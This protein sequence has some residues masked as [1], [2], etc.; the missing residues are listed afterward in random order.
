MSD[1]QYYTQNGQK[2]VYKDNALF[3]ATAWSSDSQ[4]MNVVVENGNIVKSNIY[5]SNKTIAI[6]V[7]F[8]PKQYINGVYVNTSYT[9][10]NGN[11]APLV[12]FALNPQSSPEAKYVWVNIDKTSQSYGNHG[13]WSNNP[14]GYEVHEAMLKRADAVLDLEL[15]KAN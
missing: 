11:G 1:I 13:Y 4:F 5:N 15:R 3:T 9:L 8:T 7:D 14:E 10:H 6:I 12:Q 2:V